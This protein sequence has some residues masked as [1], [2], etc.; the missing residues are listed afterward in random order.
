METMKIHEIP[1]FRFGQ[2]EDLE[3]GTGC[4]VILC[5]D[6]AMTGVDVRGA[7]PA[8]GTRMH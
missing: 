2:V 8:P 3:G 6:G 5:P 4:T 7:P 1:G